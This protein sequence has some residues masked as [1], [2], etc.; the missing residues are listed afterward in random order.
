LWPILKKLQPSAQAG[1]LLHLSWRNCTSK[2]LAGKVDHNVALQR[3]AE[4]DEI[5]N[6]VAFVAS[7]EASFITGASLLVDGGY[8]A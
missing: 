4:P 6:F 8:A 2:K 7:P 3:Y 1:N 5:A